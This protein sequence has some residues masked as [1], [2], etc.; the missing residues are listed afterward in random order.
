M[1]ECSGMCRPALFYHSLPVSEGYPVQT[2]VQEFK[3]FVDDGAV[4][5]AQAS[6]VTGVLSL[7]LFLMHIRFY[8]IKPEKKEEP[9]NPQSEVN[10]SAQGAVEMQDFDTDGNE[11]S[12]VIQIDGYQQARQDSNIKENND[13]VQF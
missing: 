1:F 8:F 4:S 12:E 9:G 3:E 7:L 13:N 5:F 2:C 10:A 11:R 6:V